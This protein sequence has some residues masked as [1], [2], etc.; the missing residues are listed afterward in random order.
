M[1]MPERSEQKK[2]RR[3][4]QG[5][6]EGWLKYEPKKRVKVDFR[7]Y[8]EAQIDEIENVLNVIRQLINEASCYVPYDARESTKRLRGKGQSNPSAAVL[9]VQQQGCC[10]GRLF[11]KNLGIYEELSYKDIERAYN[12]IEVELI[13]HKAFELCNRPLKD[14]ERDFSIDG[15]GLTTSI[16][17][18]Y[19]RDKDDKKAKKSWEKAISIIG[20]KYKMLSAAVIADSKANESP[21]LVPLLDK[22]MK[23]YSRLGLFTADAL[24]L[25]KGNCDAIAAYGGTPR[26]YPKSNTA[27]NKRGS[28]AWKEMLLAFV[29]DVQKWLTEYHIRSDTENGNSVLKRLFTRPLLKKLDQRKET[30]G[31]A[32]LCVYNVRRLNYIHALHKDIRI[33]WL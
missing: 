22:T 3:I 14:K 33:P 29:A 26:I 16:K 24:Y 7:T 18:N 11:R 25:S 15:T 4:L 12:N 8:T 32:R 13:L 1:G 28:K 23:I 5:L 17:E 20:H 9:P 31:F 2:L 6:D 21:F 19:A 27:I 10:T 30:E